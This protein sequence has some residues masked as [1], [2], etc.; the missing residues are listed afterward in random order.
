MQL[1]SCEKRRL[2]HRH[3]HREKSMW[4]QRKKTR[5]EASEATNAASMSNVTGY[6]LPIEDIFRE[7][8][9]YGAVCVLDSA[10]SMVV[11]TV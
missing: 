8:K 7:A 5:R 11:I 10:Q 9:E 2:G 3:A 6:I 4:R 1:V